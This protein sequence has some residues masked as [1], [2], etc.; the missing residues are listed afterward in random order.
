MY[1]NFE[2]RFNL[3]NHFSLF[4]GLLKEP[5]IVYGISNK[6]WIFVSSLVTAPLIII[7]FSAEL[8]GY[9]YAFTSL[10]G[11]QALFVMGTGQ[12]IQQ[13]V[14]YEWAGIKYDKNS[15]FSGDKYAIER[16]ASLK[17][18]SIKWFS[19]VSFI[20]FIGLSTGGYLFLNNSNS[21][22]TIPVYQWI[23]PWLLICLL[24]SIQI[25]IS[26]GLTYL[27]GINEVERV[28]RFRFVQS[29]NERIAAWIVIIIGGKLWL[30]SAGTGVNI[31]SQIR[32]FRKKY[33]EMLRDLLKLKT[34]K[35]FPWK[36]EILPLQWRYALSTL[37]GYINFSL[38]VPF[39]FWYL[40]PVEA[41]KTGITWAVITMLWGLSVTIISTKLPALAILASRGEFNRVNKTFLIST[42]NSLILLSASILLFYSGLIFLGNILP[43][44]S[45]R[46]LNPFTSLIF[47]L[48]IIPHHF[49]FAMINYMRALKKEPF[50]FIS[51]LES[52]VILIT[53]PLSCSNFGITGVGFTLL[54]LISLSTFVTYLIFKK[55]RYQFYK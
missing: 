2:H 25:L 20:L 48:V 4:F 53:M 36:K 28:N 24:K 51:I 17:H 31:F 14:S 21:G 41:G 16:L 32:F 52:V 27:E 18:F 10:L 47:S 39:V 15:G 46:F 38:I 34:D 3:Q 5:A 19:F 23:Y 45:I 33:F 6:I 42:I 43:S 49:R 30:F 22:S 55:F 11:I 12:L 44:V 37:S 50:W 26:P 7:F 54:I 35:K 40:G 29:L 8:Q 13:F 9:Y 1:K